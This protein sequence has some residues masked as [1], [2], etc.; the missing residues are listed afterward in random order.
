MPV[1]RAELLRSDN[2]GAVNDD[3]A[4]DTS[5]PDP[6]QLDVTPGIGLLTLFT[7]VYIF[8]ADSVSAS[9]LISESCINPVERHLVTI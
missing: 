5:V 4:K 9:A 3:P 2:Y 6:E 8:L 1:G 7:D